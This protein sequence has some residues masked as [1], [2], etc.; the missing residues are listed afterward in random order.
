MKPILLLS[1]L[2]T[3][4][5][6][7]AGYHVG[8]SKP[9]SLKKVNTIS[10]SVFANDTLHPRVGAMATSAVTSAMTQDGTYRIVS[11]EQADAVLEGTVRR[12][13]YQRIRS[14]R[15]DTLRP[16]ELD[17]TVIL[18]WVLR[19]A[20]NSTKVLASGT[21]RGSSQLFVDSNLQLARQAALPEA[22][23]RA[24]QAL[25]STLANGY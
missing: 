12:I 10:V 25:V 24:G 22:T 21:S 14:S 15:F 11:A 6:S 23:E 17:N 3:F 5:V 18:A 13:D 2:S 4:L 7:C 20:K 1:L 8:P 19:D 9:P 16:Q